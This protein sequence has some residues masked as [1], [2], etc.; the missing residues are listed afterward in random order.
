MQYPC[1]KNLPFP[2]SLYIKK[3]E[4]TKGKYIYDLINMCIN[5]NTACHFLN[6]LALLAMSIEKGDGGSEKEVKVREA[7]GWVQNRV[8]GGL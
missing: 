7:F 3:K 8:T 4:F 6:C 2:V 5:N 1:N